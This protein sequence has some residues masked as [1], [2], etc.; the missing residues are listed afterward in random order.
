MG[1]RCPHFVLHSER[2]EENGSGVQLPDS[3]DEPIGAVRV[4]A[5]DQHGTGPRFPDR[6]VDAFQPVD[7]LRLEAVKLHHQTQQRGDY[8]FARE[9]Q[10]VTHSGR[11]RRVLN[12][13]QLADPLVVWRMAGDA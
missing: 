5:V 7:E 12:T 6:V 2:T 4:V 8:L 1:C 11:P 9:N 10:N 3:L 13:R